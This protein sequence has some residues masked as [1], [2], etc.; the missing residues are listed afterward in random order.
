LI[1]TL[2]SPER[3][4]KLIDEV[5]DCILRDG[6]WV[7]GRR[8]IA[9]GSTRTIVGGPAVPRRRRY[10]RL[11]KQAGG[12]PTWLRQYVPAGTGHDAKELGLICE[13]RHFTLTVFAFDRKNPAQDTLSAISQFSTGKKFVVHDDQ[14]YTVGEKHCVANTVVPRSRTVMTLQEIADYLHVTRS[15]IHRLLK[16]RRIPAFRIGR[17]W[18]FNV[19][20]VENWCSSHTL[21]ENPKADD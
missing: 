5:L 16:H 19:E 3:R 21:C 18:R 17:H 11:G 13:R 14:L 20:E 12:L 10:S 1:V 7:K 9:Q 2:V 15:T 8:R 6:P 4:S